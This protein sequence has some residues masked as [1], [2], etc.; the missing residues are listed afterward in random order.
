MEQYEREIKK[1][2]LIM[3]LQQREGLYKSMISSQERMIGLLEEEVKVTEKL[4]ELSLKRGILIG[5]VVAT[6]ICTLIEIIVNI[7]KH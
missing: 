6:V 1:D 4:T 7:I 2:E 3:M 5:L